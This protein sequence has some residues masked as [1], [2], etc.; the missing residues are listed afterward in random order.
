MNLRRTLAAAATGLALAGAA[1]FA[2]PASAV[3]IAGIDVAVSCSGPSCTGSTPAQLTVLGGGSLSIS[4]PTP[5]AGSR[6]DLGSVNA[7]SALATTNA[8]GTV[9]V[10]DG[11]FGV[12]NN[13]WVVA[14]KASDF[15]LS[16][17][18]PSPAVTE[19]ISA[20]TVG[21]SAGTITAPVGTVATGLPAASLVSDVPVV[22]SV[23]L[24]T[25][26]VSW[27]PKLSLTAVLPNQVPGTYNGTITH[28]VL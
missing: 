27:S 5:A 12:V 6:V 9:T 13:N 24:G 2:A 3:S 18:G 1:A 4:V 22:T 17:A 19:K 14:A 7:G 23:T 20:A 26:T 25:N 10:T 28:S 16:T 8:L 15:V 11:R 21:Y